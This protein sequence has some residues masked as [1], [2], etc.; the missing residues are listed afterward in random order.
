[1]RPL[2]LPKLLAVF[3][4]C[5]TTAGGAHASDVEGAQAKFREI[6]KNGDRQIQFSEIVAVRAEMF[7][8]MDINRNG[9]LDADEIAN[10]RKVAQSSTAGQQRGMF[11][12]VDIV[13]RMKLVD[14]NGD[15]V[16]SR[17]EF[18]DFIAPEMKAADTNGDS[19]LS[20]KEM[21]SLKRQRDAAKASQ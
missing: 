4:F 20:I 1:M 18:S 7:D 12:E 17:A 21:R 10:V 5:V 16:I 2:G 3:G 13:E 15:G 8:R 14:R 19:A 9:I 11:S 6:D